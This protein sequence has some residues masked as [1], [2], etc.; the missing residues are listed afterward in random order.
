MNANFSFTSTIPN[1]ATGSSQPSCTADTTPAAFTLNDNGN[2]TADSA[3][4]TETCVNVAAGQYTVTE[5]SLAGTDFVLQSL[6]CTT[7]G[8]GGSTGTQDGTNPQKANITLVAGD[9]VTCVFVNRQQLGAIGVEKWA[10]NAN[11]GT[12]SAPAGCGTNGAPL[13]GAKF[14]LWQETNGTAGLQKGGATPDTQVNGEKTTELT[15]TGAATRAT[16]CFGNLSFDTYYVEESGPPLGYAGAANQT[17][18]V[19]AVGSCDG[20]GATAPVV[21]TVINTPLSSI[22]VK[23]TSLAGAG[24][25]VAKISCADAGGAIAPT[26]NDSTPNL[27]DDTDETITNLLPGTTANPK[28]YT[29]TILVDP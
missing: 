24:V 27:L 19:D 11:C 18:V 14:K 10:K 16:V 12:P 20:T 6:I 5:G 1:P 8:T 25:T 17:K 22:Q 13:A 4:N 7:D 23:F 2:T 26:P 15:G 28:Q 9:T 3:A 21:A 29:C